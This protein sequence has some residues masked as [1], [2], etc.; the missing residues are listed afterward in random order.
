MVTKQKYPNL[1]KTDFNFNFLSLFKFGPDNKYYLARILI[2]RIQL[3]KS[4]NKDMLIYSF[5][6][7]LW[8]KKLI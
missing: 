5:K 7:Y 2:D 8:S 1:L 3:V 6:K 4:I